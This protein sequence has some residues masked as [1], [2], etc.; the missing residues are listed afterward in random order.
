VILRVV[1]S[2]ADDEIV[3]RFRNQLV[4]RFLSHQQCVTWPYSAMI[5]GQICTSPTVQLVIRF[6]DRFEP[7]RSAD[8]FAPSDVRWHFDFATYV[9][10]SALDK[11]RQILESVHAAC[12][13]AADVNDWN[14]AP[15]NEARDGLLEKGFQ[16]LFV[17][18]KGIHIAGLPTKVRVAVQM[19]L[20]SMEVFAVVRRALRSR[21]IFVPVTTRQFVVEDYENKLLEQITTP[22]RGLLSFPTRHG[23]QSIDLISAMAER[24]AGTGGSA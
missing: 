19:E 11:K 9:E 16:H 20:E 22:G 5:K 12:L 24:E 23:D 7:R 15:F 2:Y 8:P 6:S 18:R 13:W 1:T 3:E 14:A 4:Q 10:A 17:S 21:D